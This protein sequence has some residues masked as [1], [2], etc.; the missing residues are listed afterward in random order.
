MSLSPGLK[1]LDLGCATGGISVPAARAVGPSGTVI[2]VDISPASLKIARSKAEKDNLFITFFE[3]DIKNLTG[4]EGI[5]EGT[6]DV[7]TCASA[8][9][10]LEDPAVCVQTWAKRLKTG[11]TLIFD[12]STNDSL[13]PGR[14]FDIVKQELDMFPAYGSKTAV[15]TV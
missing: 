1:V 14:C 4:L 5:E 2:A 11:G 10:L 3:H 6:F 13:V 12:T 8:M 9:V 15:G 7:I